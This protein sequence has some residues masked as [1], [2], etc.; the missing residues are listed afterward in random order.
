MAYKDILKIVP[1]LQA[2]SLAK[3][4]ADVAMKKDKKPGDIVGLGVTNIVG[5]NIIKV[6]SDLIVGL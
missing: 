1:T 2:A 6:E 3:H 5:A 4:N